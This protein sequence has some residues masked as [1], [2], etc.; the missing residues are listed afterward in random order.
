M[1]ANAPLWQDAA[2][3]S[4]SEAK[5][6]PA[7]DSRSLAAVEGLRYSLIPRALGGSKKWIHPKRFYT[8]H[9]RSVRVQNWGFHFLDPPRAL[10]K[11]ITCEQNCMVS[12]AIK[13]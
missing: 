11:S 8:L 13:V 1:K 5:R 3:S 2:W 9:L 10:G 12:S 7:R 6:E 4:C